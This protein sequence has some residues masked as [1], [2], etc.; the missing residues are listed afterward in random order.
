MHLRVL[1]VI[2][3]NV[4]F[5][6]P[7]IQPCDPNHDSHLLARLGRNLCSGRP[8]RSKMA[9]SLPAAGTHHFRLDRIFFAA[10]RRT[11]KPHERLS[12]SEMSF[13]VSLSKDKR[14]SSM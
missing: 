9:E 11:A 4:S 13:P 14:Q 2:A 3:S 6:D 5:A 10:A 1:A 7:A 12:P 8:R